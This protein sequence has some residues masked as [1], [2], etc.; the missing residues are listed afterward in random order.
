M[1]RIVL[2][3]A[4]TRADLPGIIKAMTPYSDAMDVA[5]RFL[6]RIALANQQR[7]EEAEKRLKQMTSWRDNA[8]MD[9]ANAQEELG[10]IKAALSKSNSFGSTPFEETLQI[11]ADYHDELTPW[12]SECLN[13]DPFGELEYFKKLGIPAY[14][15]ALV[16]LE[17]QLGAEAPDLREVA[18]YAAIA[19][20]YQRQEDARLFES[21]ADDAQESGTPC[22]TEDV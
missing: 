16:Y 1:D 8:C 7:A 22:E 5:V 2:T 12:K 3:E 13:S 18:Y 19:Y 20:T 11:L 15:Y 14:K 17:N 6:A 4:E 10:R 9:L 21:D